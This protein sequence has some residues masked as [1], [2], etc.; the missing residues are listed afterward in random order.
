MEHVFDVPA[1]LR[2]VHRMLRIGGRAIFFSPANNTLEHGFY[3]FSPTLFYDY[4]KANDYQINHMYLLRRARDL[5]C[6]FE[7]FAYRPEDHNFWEL[8]AIDDQVY[9][10]W[11]SVTK[12]FN[13]TCHAVPMQHRYAKEQWLTEVKESNDRFKLLLSAAHHPIL[14]TLLWKIRRTLKSL[15]AARLARQFRSHKAKL[16]DFKLWGGA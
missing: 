10:I 14:K 8:S 15:M 13:S 16:Y 7:A 12:M 3:Q 5:Y 4:F 2:H 6:D 1:A 9:L 11:V